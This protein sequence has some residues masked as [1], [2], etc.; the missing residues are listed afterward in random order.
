MIPLPLDVVNDVNMSLR[1]LCA[2]LRSRDRHVHVVND[3]VPRPIDVLTT[4]TC[5][6][7]VVT[8]PYDVANDISHVCGDAP[9]HAL[10]TCAI[11][12]DQPC[13]FR[14]TDKLMRSISC[15]IKSVAAVRACAF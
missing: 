3:V 9:L 8:V 5:R 10:H 13:C 6:Y 7:D 11:V 12:L 15:R 1:R 2:T 14:K 4:C